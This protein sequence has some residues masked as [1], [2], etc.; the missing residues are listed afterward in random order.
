VAIDLVD[1]SEFTHGDTKHLPPDL[2]RGFKFDD[3]ARLKNGELDMT[4]LLSA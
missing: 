2:L 1:A 4:V 3:A